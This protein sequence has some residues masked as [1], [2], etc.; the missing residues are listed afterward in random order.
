MYKI[1]TLKLT[2]LVGS[3]VVLKEAELH[4]QL[5]T[6]NIEW[7]SEFF[8]TIDLETDN[9]ENGL[10]YFKNKDDKVPFLCMGYSDTGFYTTVCMLKLIGELVI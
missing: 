9:D 3:D 1:Q 7:P 6:K 4:Q 5:G 8:I 10:K 2:D